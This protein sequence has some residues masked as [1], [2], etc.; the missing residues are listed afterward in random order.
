M[1]LRNKAL[2]KNIEQVGYHDLQKRPAFQIVMQ[3]C[4][5]KYYLYCASWRHNG[6]SILDVTDPTNPKMIQFKEGPWINEDCR[7]GQNTCKIQVA[8][9]LMLTAHGTMA[10]FLTGCP[11][12]CPAWCGLMVWD[13]KTDPTDPKLL[14]TFECPGGQGVHRSFYNGGRYAY[15]TGC[16]NGYESFILRIID[17]ADPTHPVEA[18]RYCVPEQIIQGESDLQFGDHLF[19]PFVHAVTVKDDIAYLAYSNVGSVLVDV[20]D[21][22]NPKMI[23]KLPLNPPFGGDAAGA[24][25]HSAYPLGDRPFAVVSTEGERSRFFDGKKT[26]GFG[27]KIEYQAMNAM[28][29]IETGDMEHPRMISVFPYP[30]MPEGYTHGENFNLVEGVRVPFGPHNCF[31]QFGTPVY[32]K[33]NN[34][35]FNCY[36]HAGLRIYD[37]HDPFVPKEIAYFLP[38]DPPEVLTDNE[39]HDVMPGSPI[40]ITED[41]VVDD[42]GYIYISTQQDGIYILKYTGEKPLD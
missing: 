30:E 26:E 36:F 2:M 17:L 19:K 33:F 7:D 28:M 6:W 16:D 35:V 10:G 21:K 31:D 13:V 39:T 11:E 9:G 20:S 40:A 14:G 1:T 29:M 22:A 18:G 38:P 42:R 24:P 3:K 12:G 41:L 8:D 32:G 5:E 27:K 34:T 15:I 4:G 37:V 25:V 23:G